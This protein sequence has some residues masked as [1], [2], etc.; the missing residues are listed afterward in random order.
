MLVLI[1]CLIFRLVLV[2][3]MF[4]VVLPDSKKTPEILEL[5]AANGFGISD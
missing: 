4:L 5:E 1:V 3:L 2:V